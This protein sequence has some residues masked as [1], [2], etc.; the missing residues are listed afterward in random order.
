MLPIKLYIYLTEFSSNCLSDWL[1]TVV[2]LQPLLDFF[3]ASVQLAP[4]A[5]HNMSSVLSIMDLPLCHLYSVCLIMQ[6]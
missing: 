4:L 3:M 1:E 6:N 2:T 5:Y